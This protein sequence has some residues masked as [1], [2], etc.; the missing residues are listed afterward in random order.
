MKRAI[1][2]LFAIVALAFPLAADKGGDG[3][4]RLQLVEATTTELQK[5]L[6]TRLVTSEQ[7]VQMYL[8]RIAAYDQVGPHLNSFIHL[9]P[10]ALDEARA[11]DANRHRGNIKSPLRRARDPQRQHRHGRPSDHG[12][13][14]RAHGI[15]SADR[16]VHH[17]QAA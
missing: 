4:A 7:L 10:H 3:S 2:V 6:Q 14:G 11:S 5:A 13:L 12:R 8:N 1:L 9:N 17:A 15:D 16:R